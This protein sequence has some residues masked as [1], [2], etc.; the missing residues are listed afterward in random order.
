MATSTISSTIT[1]LS[2]TALEG[3]V[4]TAVLKPDGQ[5]F[6][7]SDSSS[8]ASE[9]RT[10]TNASGQWSLVLEEN[11]NIDPDGSFYLVTEHMPPENGGPKTYAI[12]VGAN[13][14]TLH[15]SLIS[16]IPDGDAATYLTQA[17]ADARYQA[18]GSLSSDSPESIDQGDTA[19]AGVST[20]AARA[21][22]EHG[23]ASGYRLVHVGTSQAGSPSNGDLDVDTDDNVLY[24]RLGDA[25][26]RVIAPVTA[27]WTPTLAQGA[28]TDINKTVNWANYWRIGRLVFF[29]VKV[30]ASAAGTTNNSITLTLPVAAAGVAHMVAGSGLY[31]DNGTGTYRALPYIDVNGNLG[32]WRSSEATGVGLIG[33]VPN[34][35]VAS[36]DDF[37]ATGFY[38]A[39]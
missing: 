20:A 9:D 32:L 18:L 35:A 22:H 4:V 1:D 37:Q 17:S 21:D 33:T 10:T 29:E 16:D 12:E 23:I 31:S 7:V 15:A 14:A 38:L 34:I 30:T 13:D 26:E 39:A 25:W 24:V 2:G 5:A 3:V 36:G 27:T 19:S 28:S 8:I 11:D 6:R